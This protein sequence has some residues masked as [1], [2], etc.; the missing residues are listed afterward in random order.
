MPS[1]VLNSGHRIELYD[2]V[3]SGFYERQI[4]YQ[5]SSDNGARFV[6]RALLAGEPSDEVAVDRVSI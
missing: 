1:L 4:I 6:L 5:S 2:K 3:P